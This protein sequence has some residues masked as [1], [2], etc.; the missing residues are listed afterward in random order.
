[1][2][3]QS[4]V[5]LAVVIGAV[6]SWVPTSPAGISTAAP[7]STV[8]DLAPRRGTGRARRAPPSAGC[9]PRDRVRLDAAY[10][11]LDYPRGPIFFALIAAFI[12]AVMA[13]HR[14]AAW[15]TLL[16]GYIGFLWV[17]YLVGADS[18]PGWPASLGLAAWL[19]VLGTV[20]EVMRTR[21]ERAVEIWR[22]RAE[23]SRRGRAKERLRIAQELHDVLAHNI[24]LINVQAGVALH[25][26]D[27]QPSRRGRR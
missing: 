19:L 8:G 5:G 6:R 26:M 10:A 12:N 2:R 1:V 4:D 24:S 14:R 21:R 25:L 9:G 3:W 27:E 15:A 13:G 16:P 17:T 11:L 23:E 20:S 18:R 7:R 22:T